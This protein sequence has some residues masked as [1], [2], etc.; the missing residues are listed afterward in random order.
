MGFAIA[1]WVWS[2][3][4]VHWGC[5]GVVGS[6]LPLCRWSGVICSLLTASWGR[7]C[8]VHSLLST[9]ALRVV[10]LVRFLSIVRLCINDGVG[11][12]LVRLVSDDC[13]SYNTTGRSSLRLCLLWIVPLYHHVSSGI[14]GLTT[15]GPLR[16][17]VALRCLIVALRCLI[18]AA[19][20][21]KPLYRMTIL[22]KQVSIV[23]LRCLIVA[24]R[25]LIVALR[26][27]IVAALIA[28][29]LYRMTILRKQVSIVALRCLIVALWCLIVALRCLIVALRCLIVALRCLIVTLWCLI[30][31]ALIAKPL[32]RMTI[33]RQHLAISSITALCTGVPANEPMRGKS[34]LRF[35]CSLYIRTKPLTGVSILRFYSV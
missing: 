31:S 18:V 21:A 5:W 28:K 34:I 25:C 14:L 13:S 27:L 20:I 30:V 2:W 3:C 4:V 15:L 33:L 12:F 26:C 1:W 22:R 11:A 29:P 32:Y 6:V 16:L 23:A 10:M 9:R 24:L 8:V 35:S 7:Q 17:I 19:L